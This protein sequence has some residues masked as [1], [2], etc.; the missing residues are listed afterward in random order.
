MKKN[1]S[2]TVE[3]VKED[4]KNFLIEKDIDPELEKQ[5]GNSKDVTK[6]RVE[7]LGEKSDGNKW[8]IKK[9]NIAGEGVFAKV[10]I[11]KGD[12]IEISMKKGVVEKNWFAAKL[13]HHPEPNSQMKMFE[14][15]DVEYYA[16]KDIEVGE[17]IFNNYRE[18]ILRPE[19]ER[20]YFNRDEK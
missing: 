6:M 8:E 17:E 11:S 13:N 2:L 15:M 18:S 4:Y 14:N 12:L 19:D 20:K 10:K 9:S 3:E 1:T 16:L 5:L 7:M